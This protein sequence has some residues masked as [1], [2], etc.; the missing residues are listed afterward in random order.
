M[1]NP[2][3]PL[4]SNIQAARAVAALCVVA[5]HLGVMP[6]GQIGVDVF[7]VISGFIMSY[8]APK[9]GNAFFIKRVI[10]IV[11]LYWMLTIGVYAIAVVRPQ[12]LNTTTDGVAYLFKS[13]FFVPYV[14][15]NGNWGPLLRNGWTLDFEMFFYVVVAAALVVVR[16]QYATIAASAALIVFCLS[17]QAVGAGS[18]VADYLAQ[19]LVIE[20]CLG[21]A[22]YWITRA[23]AFDAAPRG[24]F[25][26]GAIAAPLL[27]VALYPEFGDPV[28]FQRVLQYGVPAFVLI[29][30]L[31]GLEKSGV[32][33][34]NAILANLGAAS[35]SIYLLHPYVIGVAEK[36]LKIHP[37]AGT[38]GGWCAAAAVALVVCAAGWVCY[39]Y[40]EMPI[41]SALR[42]RSSAERPMS[43]RAN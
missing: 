26:A 42:W 1:K 23:R 27:V 43:A 15:E 2:A 39:R 18:Q 24:L 33:S 4:L 16:R 28:G 25:G 31:L 34:R 17:S 21:V 7:F 11:P 14:K 8:V 10:R 32:S 12:W 35:Y 41:Q 19:P 29:A 40:V 13:M 30:S 9:E 3:G 36:I 37:G 5:Y 22:C 6:F 20:F 38:V